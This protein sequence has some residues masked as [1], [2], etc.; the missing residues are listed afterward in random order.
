MGIVI[1]EL[2]GKVSLVSG[3]SRGIGRAIAVM[4]AEHG[5]DVVVNYIS[6]EAAAQD[7]VR[8]IRKVG[9]RALACKADVSK[10]EECSAMVETA[11]KELGPIQILVNNAG[12]TRDKSFLKLSPEHWREVIVTHLD[13]AFNLT[14]KLLPNMIESK[15]GRVINITSIVGQVGNFGQTN[16]AVAKGGLMAFTKTLAREVA[17][18][19]VTVNA[20]SPGFIETD[21]TAAVPPNVLETVKQMTPVGRLGLPEEVAAAVCFL[22][23]PKASFI[24][25]TIINVNGGMYM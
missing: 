12:I 23:G 6:N 25:G 9:R 21:M 7:V 4:L 8:E 24:T 11:Q 16:Y 2:Q 14:G 5:S 15:W 13:G 19:G 3:S 10:R 1:M 22:A 18:K 20:V 17:L